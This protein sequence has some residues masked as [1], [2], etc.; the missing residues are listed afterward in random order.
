[1]TAPENRN[2]IV[3]KE[4]GETLPVCT[5]ALEWRRIMKRREFLLAI[6]AIPLVMTVVGRARSAPLADA[7]GG[8]SLDEIQRN[9]KTLLAQGADVTLSTEAIQKSEGEW[10]QVL[11]G[12][13]FHVL[14]TEGTER[15]FSSSLNDEKRAGVYVCAGCALHC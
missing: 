2:R 9:W 4:I 1:L 7:G 8:M 6:T 12:P 15:P 14:R 5:V 10:Q 3:R 11:S 13:Q